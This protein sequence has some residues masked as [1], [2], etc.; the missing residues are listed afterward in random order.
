MPEFSMQA[1]EQFQAEE[2]LFGEYPEKP[3]GGGTLY[4]VRLICTVHC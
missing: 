2:H 3:G 4:E 1:E